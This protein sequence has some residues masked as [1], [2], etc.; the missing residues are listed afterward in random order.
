MG[1]SKTKEKIIEVAT[2][3]FYRHG[4]VKASIR[5]IVG[6][7]GVTNATFYI[8]FA[9]KAE[10][11][12]YIIEGIGSTL[13]Q[14][15]QQVIDANDDPKEC[16]REMIYRQVCLMKEKRKEIRIYVEEQ[17][18]LPIVLRDKAL[19]QHRQIYELFKNKISEITESGLIH[20]LDDTVVTFSIFAMMN[21]VYRWFC[22]DG[23]LSVEEVANQVTQ[24]LFKGIFGNSAAN[25]EGLERLAAV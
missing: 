10:I 15:L 7:V 24:I 4:F 19:S 8:H 18:Q 14:E 5:V 16:L 11:L 13:L 12:Y 1:D 2:D 6:K 21:W 9:N 3:L 20:G 23:K 17:Y 22:D 25:T